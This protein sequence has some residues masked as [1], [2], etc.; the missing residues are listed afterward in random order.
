MYAV[1]LVAL[2]F[3]LVFDFAVIDLLDRRERIDKNVA[4]AGGADALRAT[5]GAEVAVDAF[6]IRVY[7]AGARDAALEGW[8]ETGDDWWKY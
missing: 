6:G 3:V 4:L 7:R 8:L 1:F 5:L 2:F